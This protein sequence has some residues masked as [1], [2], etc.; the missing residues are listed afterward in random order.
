MHDA[1]KARAAIMILSWLLGASPAAAKPIPTGNGRQT[2]DVDGT[3]LVLFTYRPACPDPS[4]LLVFHGVARNAAAYRDD[5]RVLADRDCLLVVAPLFDKRAFPLWRYQRG[6]IVK[7]GMVQSTGQWTGRLVPALVDRVRRQEG[8]PLPY[9]LL[10]HSAGAQF[11]D[12][13]AAFV[14]TEARR[15]VVANPGSYVFPSLETSAPY[16]LGKVYA[17]ADGEAALRQYL[18]QPL[19]IY[20]GQGDTRENERD[21]SLDAQ[22]QGASRHRRGVNAF[23]AG[24]ALAQARG[25]TFKWRLT[26]LPGVGHN[27]RK[28]FAAPQASAALSP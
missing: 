8:N 11:L 3:R 18:A 21:D 22:A 4:L 27:A 19:T 23:N 10:G 25:W 24:R 28:M 2:I 12:R 9:S 26:E 14:P 1:T 6:G 5:A 7:D 16:G 17:G 15:I 13:L 20:L